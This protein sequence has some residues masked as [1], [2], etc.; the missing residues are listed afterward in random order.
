M[1]NSPSNPHSSL[2]VAGCEAALIRAHLHATLQTAY[3]SRGTSAELAGQWTI[4]QLR[5]LIVCMEAYA[6]E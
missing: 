2:R 5:D 6:H 3:L 4:A 1:S